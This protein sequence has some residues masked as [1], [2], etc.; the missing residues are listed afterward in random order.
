MNQGR[1]VASGPGQAGGPGR[2][3]YGSRLGSEVGAAGPTATPLDIGSVW[4]RARRGYRSGREVRSGGAQR[5][6]RVGE[7]GS[8]WAFSCHRHSL[9]MFVEVVR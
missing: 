7:G 9:L 6:W 5:R 4:W 8:G 1:R 2:C 3:R